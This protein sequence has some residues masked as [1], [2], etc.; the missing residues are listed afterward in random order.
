MKSGIVSDRAEP[1]QKNP[2]NGL[3]GYISKNW[4]YLLAAGIAIPAL[5]IGVAGKKMHIT[6]WDVYSALTE[7]PAVTVVDNNAGR[8]DG[9]IKLPDGS[10]V[11]LAPA[12]V[13]PTQ[14]PEPKVLKSE[15]GLASVE[16]VS[17]SNCTQEELQK[18]LN[19]VHTLSTGDQP[20]KGVIADSYVYADG[21][22]VKQDGKKVLLSWRR[23]YA[24]AAGGEIAVEVE[25]GQLSADAINSLSEN[26]GEAYNSLLSTFNPS[27]KPNAYVSISQ[28]GKRANITVDAGLDLSRLAGARDL[29]SAW[30]PWHV[31]DDLGQIKYEMGTNFDMAFGYANPDDVFLREFLGQ[32]ASGGTSEKYSR[33]RLE[34]FSAGKAYSQQKPD[35]FQ[36]TELGVDVDIALKK[37]G[38]DN[39]LFSKLMQRIEGKKV[40]WEQFKTEADAVAGR[41]LETLDYIDQGVKLWRESKN[42]TSS[43]HPSGIGK[44]NKSI[45][46]KQQ[47][48]EFERKALARVRSYKI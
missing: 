38:F 20:V 26:L 7:R 31:T 35:S 46:W 43:I 27:K 4:K 10:T 30:R 23:D 29:N 11:T 9:G 47:R 15:D 25:Y 5:A 41:H 39:L 48:D 24:P 8:Y 16:C 12:T 22:L 36:Q 2:L 13:T 33:W 3:G 14:K 17:T 19:D 32:W 28:D 37:E 6:D 42:K 1:Y 21:K 44:G 40:R 34:Q 18:Y 45:I